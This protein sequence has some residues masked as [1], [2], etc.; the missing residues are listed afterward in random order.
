MSSIWKGQNMPDLLKK[1]L[2][3]YSLISVL[4]LLSCLLLTAS[5]CNTEIRTS[6]I[7]FTMETPTGLAIA[8]VDAADILPSWSPDGS[9]IAFTSLRDGNLEIYTMNA[10]GSNQ[11][12][13]TNDDSADIF[14]A[15]SPDASQVAFQSNR[16][17]LYDIYAVNADGTGLTQLTNTHADSETP[18][19]SPDGSRILLVERSTYTTTIMIYDVVSGEITATVTNGFAPCWSPDIPAA[20]T[21]AG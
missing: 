18:A 13:L 8:L 9:I 15:W 11:T 21:P 10:D 4:S 20:G 19:W 1:H 16:D 3:F 6:G 7:A 5:G 12:R 17:G 2:K 14:P